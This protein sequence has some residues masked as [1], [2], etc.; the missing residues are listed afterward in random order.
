M[1]TNSLPADTLHDERATA[2][3]LSVE[4]ATLAVWRSTRRYNLPYVKVGR[5]V[6][7]RHSDIMAFIASRTV[8]A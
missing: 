3:I 2:E 7:Y 1:A 6:R 4:P 5:A 8:A